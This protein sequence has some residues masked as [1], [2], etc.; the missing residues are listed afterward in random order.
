MD[1]RYPIKNILNKLGLINNETGIAS[2]K[3]INPRC[4]GA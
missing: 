4:E 1:K 3:L 2:H